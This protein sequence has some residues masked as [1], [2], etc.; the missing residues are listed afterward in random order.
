[1]IFG[2]TCSIRGFKVHESME[3]TPCTKCFGKGVK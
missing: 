1:M 3:K 2:K